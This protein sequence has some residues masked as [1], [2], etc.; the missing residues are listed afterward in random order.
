V[1]QRDMIACEIRPT[2]VLFT[3]AICG[4]LKIHEFPQGCAQS[5]NFLQ[6][7]K[8]MLLRKTAGQ[9]VSTHVLQR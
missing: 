7:R 6:Q 2:L 3:L 5:L 4:D 9:A 1:F 8:R